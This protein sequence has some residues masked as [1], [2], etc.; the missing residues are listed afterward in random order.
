MT[1]LEPWGIPKFQ[2]RVEKK[3][4]GEMKKNSQASKKKVKTPN[5]IIS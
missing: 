4:G 1:K 3:T 2:E 5:L